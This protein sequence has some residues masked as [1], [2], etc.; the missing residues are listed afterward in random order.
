MFFAQCYWLLN[1]AMSTV[2][3]EF[4]IHRTPTTNKMVRGKTDRKKW[5][6]K[7][8][9][10]EKNTWH[11][12]V[13]V[14]LVAG[15]EQV[16]CLMRYVVFI[17]DTFQCDFRWIQ[18]RMHEFSSSSSVVLCV[19]GI[20]WKCSMFRLE[21][22]VSTA[23]IKKKRIKRKCVSHSGYLEVLANVYLLIA[24]SQGYEC[25]C[26]KFKLLRINRPIECSLSGE[27]LTLIKLIFSTGKSANS[28]CTWL[29]K[30]HK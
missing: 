2:C 10:S 12:H 11:A 14:L 18:V 22:V 3:F 16:G 5:R 15:Y 24:F 20:R 19:K 29:I 30:H 7:E 21:C 26:R 9:E 13:L 6:E 4:T 8:R 1:N 25:V 23:F 17:I 28:V 27:C